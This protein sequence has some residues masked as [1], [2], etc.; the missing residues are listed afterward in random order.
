MK[1]REVKRCYIGALHVIN[2]R[3][4]VH[5]VIRTE[6]LF[7]KS[8]RRRKACELRSEIRIN[9]QFPLYDS[10]KFFFR[11]KKRK[12]SNHSKQ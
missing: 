5:L 11:I 9:K 2:K 7:K 6:E 3:F 8:D 4:G 12:V 1:K 10:D